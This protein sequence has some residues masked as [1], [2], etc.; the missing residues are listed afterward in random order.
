MTTA[1][2]AAMELLDTLKAFTHKV[3]SYEE[4]ENVVKGVCILICCMLNYCRELF[5]ETVG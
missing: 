1:G 4:G 3:F 2:Q 5:T